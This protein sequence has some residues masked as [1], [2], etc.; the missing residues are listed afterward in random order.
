MKPLPGI[1]PGP[2]TN[3]V[4]VLTITP[5]RHDLLSEGTR[6]WLLKVTYLQTFLCIYKGLEPSNWK[7]QLTD[8]ESNLAALKFV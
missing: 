6:H 7:H 2:S 1:E 4:D 3:Q 5:Q 8:N